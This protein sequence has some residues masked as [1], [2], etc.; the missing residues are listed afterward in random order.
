MRENQGG[1]FDKFDDKPQVWMSFDEPLENICEYYDLAV[2]NKKDDDG[3]TDPACAYYYSCKECVKEAK[4]VGIHLQELKPRGQ[5]DG[6][7]MEDGDY[8]R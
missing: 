8:G 3:N 7:Y 6:L 4:E 2:S 1:L 5:E